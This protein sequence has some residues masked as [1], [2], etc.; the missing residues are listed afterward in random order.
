M[1]TAEELRLYRRKRRRIIV[2]VIAI[3]IVIVGGS[4]GFRPA[5]GAVKG[6]QAR[7]HAHKAFAAIEKE[8]WQDAQDEAIAAF[9][10][11]PKEP[12]AVRAV[13]RFLSRTR[14]AEAL[15]YW[16]E[17]EKIAPLTAEDRRDEVTVALAASD[18]QRPEAA[19]SVLLKSAHPTP[20]AAQVDAQ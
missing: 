6:W 5:R 17:L 9:Q 1:M 18:T 20:T 8:K 15:E 12:Q 3:L 4:F 19:I 2:L 14:Q 13:A 10:L 7:R 16:N 11:R